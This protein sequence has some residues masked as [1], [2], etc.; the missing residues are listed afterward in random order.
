MK[1]LPAEGNGNKQYFLCLGFSPLEVMPNITHPASLAHGKRAGWVQGAKLV[2][3]PLRW[4]CVCSGSVQYPAFAPVSRFFRSKVA[5]GYFGPW[6][7]CPEF[8]IPNRSFTVI[9]GLMQSLYSVAQGEVYSNAGIVALQQRVLQLPS[10][11]QRGRGRQW[12]STCGIDGA[13]E[14]ESA[15][16]EMGDL[17]SHRLKSGSMIVCDNAE[18]PQSRRD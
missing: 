15:Q 12:D 9:F 8:Q 1:A 2:S 11:S 4:C 6:S 5:V 18:Q 7:F 3:P 14:R 16:S 10:L 13:S 17:L